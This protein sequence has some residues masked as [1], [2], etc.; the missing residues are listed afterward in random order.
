MADTPLG[1][2]A[3]ELMKLGAL[4]GL[5]IGYR[6]TELGRP[7][8]QDGAKRLIKAA[9]LG[10]VSI[11]ASPMNTLAG[12][13]AFKSGDELKAEI[14][15]LSEL[16]LVLREAVGWSRSQTEAV[17]SNFQAKA[18]QGEPDVAEIVAALRR[19]LSILQG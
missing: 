4:K 11:V 10:E 3:Y 7:A 15:T 6:P 1:R 17:L 13:T 12:V 18:S 5:S 8:M 2:E 9:K 16:G 19:N 14:K